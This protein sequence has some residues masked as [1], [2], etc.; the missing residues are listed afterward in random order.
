[1]REGAG[2]ALLCRTEA[3]DALDRDTTYSAL[4]DGGLFG[5]GAVAVVGAVLIGLALSAQDDGDVQ[6]VANVSLSGGEVGVAGRF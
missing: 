1:V 5:G 4:A 6:P 3:G 2:G